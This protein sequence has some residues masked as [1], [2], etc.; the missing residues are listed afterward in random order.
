MSGRKRGSGR[1]RRAAERVG[2]LHRKVARQR[3]D[4]HHQLS[5]RLVNEHHLIVHEQLQVPNMTRRPKPK[6]D[7]DGGYLPNGARAKAGLNREISGAGWG[8]LLAMVAYKAEEAGRCLVAVDPRFSSQA[9][10][11]CGHVSERNRQG[12]VFRC[13]ACGHSDHADVNAARNILRAGLAQH[14]ECEATEPA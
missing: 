10:H 5:R 4:H 2:A 3:R 11:R 7:R 9:C 1:R 6:K 12:A 8:Q 13:V 14:L